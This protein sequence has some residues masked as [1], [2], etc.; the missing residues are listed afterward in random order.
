MEG[1]QARSVGTVSERLPLFPL[2]TVLFPGLVLPLHIF[3]PRYRRLV[4]DLLGGPSPMRFGVIAIREGRETGVRGVSALHE[5]GCVAAVKEIT[6]LD[7]GR[8]DLLTVGTQRF[9]LGARGRCPTYR[10]V[11]LLG[12]PSGDR[13]AGRGVRGA[14]RSAGTRT[15]GDGGIG[16]DQRSA[17]RAG[18]AVLPGSVCHD[19]RA[20]G[21]ARTHRPARRRQPLAAERALLNFSRGRHF[22][23][24]LF[25]SARTPGAGPAFRSVS[26]T[27]RAS[28][29]G[30]QEGGGAG[31]Y[32][33]GSIRVGAHARAERPRG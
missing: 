16:R 24:A 17:G 3:E 22:A 15:P 21:P 25:C 18:S 28:W 23:S 14:A 20:A 1:R 9:R 19:H 13:P 33:G 11:E 32:F 2:G 10:D 12:D 31:A 30:G 26:P 5:V 4:R 27:F 8:Y 6:E 7:E 29:L